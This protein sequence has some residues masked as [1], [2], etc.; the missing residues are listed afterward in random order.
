MREGVGGRV[1]ARTASREITDATDR[2]QTERDTPTHPG[3][4]EFDLSPHQRDT[5]GEQNDGQRE[6]AHTEEF[7]ERFGDGVPDGAEGP[8]FGERD[9]E[10]DD[11]QRQNPEVTLVSLKHVRMLGRRR[12]SLRARGR[13]LDRLFLVSRSC[14]N[15][16]TY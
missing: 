1:Q 3:P 16:L 7:R 10:P 2:D 15:H 12:S 5:Q 11:D 4:V 14:H 8:G 13:L 6:S 9:E